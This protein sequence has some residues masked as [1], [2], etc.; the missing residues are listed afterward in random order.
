MCKGL[1]EPGGPYRCSDDMQVNYDRALTTLRSRSEQK[2]EAAQR[3]SALTELIAARPDAGG[4]ALQSDQRLARLRLSQAEAAEAAAWKSLAHASRERDATPRGLAQ[5]ALLLGDARDRGDG[6]LSISVR[7]RVDQALARMDDE[8]RVRQGRRREGARAPKPFVHEIVP[9]GTVTP[10]PFD[11]LARRDGVAVIAK[12]YYSKGPG[13]RQVRVFRFV[14]AEPKPRMVEF[15]I[16]DP[17]P[18]AASILAERAR[19]AAAHGASTAQ[20]GTPLTQDRR[21][22][23]KAHEHLVR[24]FGESG[25]NEYVAA[26]RSTSP[27]ADSARVRR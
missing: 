16:D 8:A 19:Q 3:L 14:A 21:R 9:R 2:G 6:D 22:A 17:A 13:A 1:H 26:A 5:L 23:L 10:S 12:V 4:T 7:A 25:A 15:T 20:P 18:T 11:D 27:D 24:L